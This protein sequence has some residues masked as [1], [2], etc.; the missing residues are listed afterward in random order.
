M[1]FVGI[2]G[3]GVHHLFVFR[4]C[5]PIQGW[6]VVRGGEIFIRRDCISKYRLVF[7]IMAQENG[8]KINASSVDPCWGLKRFFVA[9]GDV[10][11]S[12]VGVD[13]HCRDIRQG[14][15]LKYF[16]GESYC[17]RIKCSAAN[18]LAALIWRWYLN[19]GF[20]SYSYY[21]RT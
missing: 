14:K 13:K 3:S 16:R 15:I 1:I 20:Q 5:G 8:P 6:G 17:H 12:L 9:Q 21:V 2:L 18:P 4:A 10:L 7:I 19:S 11:G